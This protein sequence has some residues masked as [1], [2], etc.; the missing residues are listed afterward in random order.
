MCGCSFQDKIA[1]CRYWPLEVMRTSLPSGGNKGKKDDDG[2]IGFHG[3]VYLD[4][5]PLLYPG[6][7]RIHGAYKIMAYSDQELS[8]KVSSVLPQL[9]KSG[10]CMLIISY[11]IVTGST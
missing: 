7:R 8:E 1:K 3:I 2:H 9:L 11:D 4:L 10:V 5:A 6:V